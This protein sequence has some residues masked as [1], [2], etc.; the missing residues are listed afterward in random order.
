MD[1]CDENKDIDVRTVDMSFRISLASMRKRFK[2]KEN[3]Y[4][5]I[6][7]FISKLILN[8]VKDMT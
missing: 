5:K 8:S 3:S 7:L 6:I 2:H 1:L 4:G